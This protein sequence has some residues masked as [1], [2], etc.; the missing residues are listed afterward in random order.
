MVNL[1]KTQIASLQNEELKVKHL[2]HATTVCN[3]TVQEIFFGEGAKWE[4]AQRPDYA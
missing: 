1:K 2:V 3:I 4:M